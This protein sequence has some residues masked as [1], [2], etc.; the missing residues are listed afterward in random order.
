MFAVDTLDKQVWHL[1]LMWYVWEHIMIFGREK[2]KEFI[3]DW[4][5][6]GYFKPTFSVEFEW[7]RFTCKNNKPHTKSQ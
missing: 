2:C 6:L 1:I 3:P 4:F 7:R 5:S